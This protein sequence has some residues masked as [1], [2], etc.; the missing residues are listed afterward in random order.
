MTSSCEARNGKELGGGFELPP[1]TVSVD[2]PRKYRP[3]TPKA[4]EGPES[5]SQTVE[6]GVLDTLHLLAEHIELME[7]LLVK[8]N[9]MLN[10][11]TSKVEHLSARMDDGLDVVAAEVSEISVS[12]DKHLALRLIKNVSKTSGNPCSPLIGAEEGAKLVSTIATKYGFRGNYN[13]LDP[14]SVKA[15]HFLCK[16][17]LLSRR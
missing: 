17:L 5:E 15:Q 2:V 4:D 10:H 8:Q 1:I 12:V 16:N 13:Y 11:L 3:A 9:A 7:G 14:Y 6:G